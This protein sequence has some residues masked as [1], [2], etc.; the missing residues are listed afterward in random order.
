MSLNVIQRIAGGFGLLLLLLLGIGSTGFI[1]TQ[2]INQKLHLITDETTPLSNGAYRQNI[3][4][5][6]ANKALQYF[7]ASEDP[8]RLEQEK[9][10]FTN[11][12]ASYESTSTELHD[13]LVDAPDTEALLS[14]SHDAVSQYVTI[15][16]Q[17]M[18]LHEQN[19]EQS[20]K[21]RAQHQ[22]MKRQDESLNNFLRNYAIRTERTYGASGPQIQSNNLLR[23]VNKISTQFDR[24]D[25]T[26]DIKGLT[27]GIQG[28]VEAI[29]KREQEFQTVDNA[30][31]LK[32]QILIKQA[33]YN[34]SDANGLYQLYVTQ[35]SL[36]HQIQDAISQ[37]EQT[38]QT[39]LDTLD[40]FASQAVNASATATTAG[41]HTIE[42]SSSILISV[43]IIAIASALVIG[44]WVAMSIR[45]PLN[46]FRQTLTRITQGDLRVR[47][48]AGRKDE[49]GELGQSLN[50]LTGTLQQTLGELLS[51]AD[52]LADTAEGNARISEQT[53]SAVHDQQ[54]QLTSAASSM[55]EMES[56]VH[57]VANRAQ[58][59]MDAVDD[60]S[61]LASQA[62]D[63]V[64]DTISSIRSQAAQINHASTVTDE[65]KT[66]SANIDSILSAIRN[67]AE[68]TNLLAL[69][70]AIEA[71]RAGEQGR[72]FAVVADEVR[73]L[74]SRTQQ[75]TG[76]IQNMIEQMQNRISEVVRV[77]GISQSQS[78]SCVSVAASAGQALEQMNASIE[79]IRDMNILIASATEQ[80]SA[81]AQEISQNVSQ[82]SNAA[83]Q[84]ADGARS[85][86]DS[87]H[88]LLDMARHQRQLL[89]RFSV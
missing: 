35:D 66:Y 74:A 70:A 87:S 10:N 32:V 17:L 44:W 78:E 73:T 76:E 57:D 88:N 50:E 54:M 65:L 67:I 30:Q 47:F 82:I 80:Q 23:E 24:Y 16:Q 28:L 15:A 22:Q 5:L 72:G 39:T 63:S 6:L 36:K 49:F 9:T 69:N 84:T 86:A 79:R 59:T 27:D 81:T 75:S 26:R 3:Q 33:I 85:T 89:Q 52:R 25:V 31:A 41:D 68:Q 1:S 19:I 56:T 51:S 8:Q 12:I 21:V 61:R 55:T 42:T 53:T 43:C 11:A 77:M 40:Q 46:A 45:R 29:Q 4:L 13:Y 14:Q 2:T 60:S 38:I 58:E 20:S 62:R 37:A 7:L 48:D 64:N 83:E 34:L 71:A 18:A